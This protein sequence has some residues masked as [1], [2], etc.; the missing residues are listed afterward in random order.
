[1]DLTL[2]YDNISKLKKGPWPQVAT[3]GVGRPSNWKENFALQN[4]IAMESI[5]I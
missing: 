5:K 1:M 4:L 2:D 3:A